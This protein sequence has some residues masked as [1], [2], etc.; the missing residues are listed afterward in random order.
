MSWWDTEPHKR[1]IH[2][3]TL[4]ELQAFAKSVGRN[5]RNELAIK[6]WPNGKVPVDRQGNSYQLLYNLR[7]S[8]G[9]EW[10]YHFKLEQPK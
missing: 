7:N 5:W 4:A 6:F 10:L 9:P 1:P 8:H 3:D 2:P